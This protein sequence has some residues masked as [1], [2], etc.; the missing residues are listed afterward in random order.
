[1]QDEIMIS[2]RHFELYLQSSKVFPTMKGIMLMLMFVG[3]G[4]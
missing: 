2:N 1:M 3:S 4:N